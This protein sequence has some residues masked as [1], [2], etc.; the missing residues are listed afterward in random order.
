MHPNFL[1]PCRKWLHFSEIGELECVFFREATFAKEVA[2]HRQLVAQPVVYGHLSSVY[3]P[4]RMPVTTRIVISLVG[5]P[6]LN[7]D[8]LLFLGVGVDLMYI[9]SPNF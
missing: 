4:P 6:N 1:G 2:K 3:S 5:N 9:A 8:L 7:L